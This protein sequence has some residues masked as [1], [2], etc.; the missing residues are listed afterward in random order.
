MYMIKCY[1]K[2]GDVDHVE[3]ATS[4]QE[5]EKIRT[6]WGIKIGLKPEPSIDFPRYPTIWINENDYHCSG[7]GYVRIEGY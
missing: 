1:K 6:K 3:F 4:L 5:A 7:E 2:N